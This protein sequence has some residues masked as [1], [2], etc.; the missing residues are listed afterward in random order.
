[1]Y[2]KK[3]TLILIIGIICSFSVRAFGTV[4]PQM[5]ENV[6]MVKGTI[7]VHF[8]FIMSHLFFWVFFYKEYASTK[9]TVLKKACLLVIIGSTAVAVLYI[10]YIPFVF[11]MKVLFPLFL[12]SPYVDTLVPFVSTIFQ[13]IFF[14]AF[15][16]VTESKEREVL[17][18]PIVAIIVGISIFLSFHLIVML[19]F[20][21]ANQFE[22]L[23]H[24]PRMV[25]AGTVPLLIAAVFLILYFYYRFYC[26]LDLSYDAVEKNRH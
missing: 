9:T 19:N 2:L 10:K 12:M 7:L 17:H 25:A 8:F 11:D 23:E 15:K 21:S 13:L 1:M 16:N 3:M 5:F 14:V 18:K 6:Y 20:L 24:M 4:F 26:F 22:W